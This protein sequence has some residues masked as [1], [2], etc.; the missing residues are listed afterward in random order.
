MAAS[1]AVTPSRGLDSGQ[2]IIQD[3]VGDGAACGQGSQVRVRG[4]RCNGRVQEDLRV[5]RG[6]G[7]AVWVA[8]CGGVDVLVERELLVHGQA[9]CVL[10]LPEGKQGGER[11]LVERAVANGR[12]GQQQIEFPHLVTRGEPEPQEAMR[13]IEETKALRRSGKPGPFGA[14]G[15]ASD[16]LLVMQVSSTPWIATFSPSCTQATSRSS[17]SDS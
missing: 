3:R 4:D 12:G 2:V 5:Q 10:E 14:P 6:S 15:G 13:A 9:C 1:A 16:C 7:R 8:V 17:S 11:V